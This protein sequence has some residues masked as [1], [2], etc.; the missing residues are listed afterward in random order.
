MIGAFGLE[1]G[2][3]FFELISDQNVPEHLH[4]K[5][6]ADESRQNF[7][8][9]HF[10]ATKKVAKKAAPKKKVAKKVAKKPTKKVTKKKAPAKKKTT[11]TKG[12]K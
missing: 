1:R 5:S 12:K 7:L 4:S 2:S 9:T 6:E 8:L 11:R 3:L 10:I